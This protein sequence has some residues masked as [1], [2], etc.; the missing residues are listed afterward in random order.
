MTSDLKRIREALEKRGE[1]SRGRVRVFVALKAKN[2]EQRLL[3]RLRALGLS[4]DRVIDSTIVGAVPRS[5]IN[6]GGPG[7]TEMEESV[8]LEAH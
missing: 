4:I 5:R 2:P 6:E 8:R 7:V 1:D 3:D